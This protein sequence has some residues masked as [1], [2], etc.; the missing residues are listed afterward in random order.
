MAVH[1]RGADF[2]EG[3]DDED[4]RVNQL[5]VC[6]LSHFSHISMSR[7]YKLLFLV[8]MRYLLE[9]DN[10][11]TTA[12]YK[13]FLDGC[14]S[15]EI[16]AVFDEIEGVERDEVRIGG[17][18][19]K[20]LKISGEIECDL[21]GDIVDIIHSIAHEYG[22]ISRNEINKVLKGIPTYRETNVGEIISLE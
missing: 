3:N 14:Y 22:E 7:V 19:V 18:S 4:D 11:F 15:E 9:N 5:V 8:E 21:D 16:E 6:L 1:D 13:K 12:K 2:R 17:D 10:R 20:T